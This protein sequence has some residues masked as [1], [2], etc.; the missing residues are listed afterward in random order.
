MKNNLNKTILAVAIS[1]I[2]SASANAAITDIIISE[3]V[4]GTGYNKAIELTNTG[5]EDYTFTSNI[6][7]QW[8]AYNNQ[9]LDAD[10]NNVLE[11]LKIEA[12]ATAVIYHGTAGED[13]TNAIIASTA[14]SVRAATWG[15]QGYGALN[16]NGDDHV[17]LIDT[18]NIDYDDYEE[19]DLIILDIIG[20]FG[21]EIYWGK[22]QTLRRRYGE[23]DV[24][25][26]QSS[27]Y[28]EFEW[29]VFDVDSFDDLGTATYS[30]YQEGG[31]ALTFCVLD[32]QTL[33]SEAQGDGGSSPLID[34]GYMSD[35][36]YDFT[37]IV[38]AVTRY[39]VRGFYMQ[40]VE[41][42]GDVAT[43]DGI[44]VST[45]DA[46]DDMVGNT[47]CVNSYVHEYYSLTRL[48]TDEW[49]IVDETSSVPEAT[50]IEIISADGGSFNAT[51]ERYEGM[52][53]RLPEDL[54][55]NTTDSENMRVTQTFG[56]N[57]DTYRNSMIL[58]YKRPNMNP[59]Q[60]NVAG[61]DEA[62]EAAAENIDYRLIIESKESADDG[63]IPYYPAFSSNPDSNYIRINDSVI[64]MEGVVSYSYGDFN[65]VVTNELTSSNFIHNTDR[66]DSPDLETTTTDDSFVIKVGAQNV[67]NLFNSPFGGDENIHGDNRG[68]ESE[69][70]Y[71][72]QLA[73]IVSAIVALDADIVG[74]MEIENN[75]YGRD[76]AI[77]ALIDAVNANYWDEDPKDVDTAAS[78]SNRYVF[79]GYDENGDLVLDSLDSLGSDAI[80][81]GLIYRPT[82][83]TIE[84]MQVI[85]M[86]EQHAPVV[87]NDNNVVVKDSSG[88]VLESGDN[89]QRETIAATFKVNNTGK[90]LTI[91]VNHFKSKGSTCWED[92]DGV[93][94]GEEV[95]WSDDAP[96]EDLQGSCENLRVAASVQ[97]GEE[98]ADVGGDRII[99][100]D[101]NSYNQ[102]DPLLVLTEN[103]TNKT[104]MAARD[105]F[106][107]DKPQFTTG[108]S[109][110][111]ITKTYGYINAVSLKNE[112]KNQTS[113]SYSY[114]D[115]IGSLD[116]I[117]ISPS[118]ETRLIDAVDWHINAA[119]SSLYDYADAYKGDYAASFYVGDAF[120]SSDHDP[121]IIA[122]SY[123]YGEVENGERVILT[124]DSRLLTIPYLLGEGTLTS[125]IIRI[126]LSSEVNMSDVVLPNLS[127]TEDNQALAEI[128]V[129]GL[130]TGTYT[131]TMTLI[132]DDE[133]LT[134]FTEVM[135]FEAI[136]QDSTIATVAP[137]EEY[138]GS[139]GSIG[140]FGL[141][142]LFG[143]GFLRNRKKNDSPLKI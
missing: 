126:S 38:T 46:T 66:T 28:N 44:F 85:S 35:N 27:S 62:I 3:Y 140:I 98:L 138:D 105:T 34:S 139:G 124:L 13:L 43:S 58:A 10:G 25:P 87:V 96:N 133:V 80:T 130:E 121:V 16:F 39:P 101:L 12:G 55:P 92:W 71:Q 142:S 47:V 26:V 73:K 137:V 29:E 94:F 69:D 127:L 78:I 89:Y 88:E 50:D 54:N 110:Q 86:P 53:V 67:L 141:L 22:D 143:L 108:G 95:T 18:S 49:D 36:A 30:P 115:E 72:K 4:E 116:H 76:S 20:T 5:S 97:L 132:R 74:L 21:T 56:F 111:E 23:G 61:S 117:L 136:N 122:L 90:T 7:L 52:L 119:E 81:T 125:D 93:A 128:E 109:A 33:I 135:R 42:D 114:N 131:A 77:Q 6:D 57:Y 41:P 70:E 48:V 91:A 84:S 106:I 31:G 60:D 107:G 65:L 63:E 8:G 79:V 1:G 19:E 112:E 99:V 2:L 120:R 11:D 40:D 118:L 32:E 75:G 102:E 59:T 104:I 123:Q 113:W 82:K 17:A 45:S 37:G 51:L 103:A 64:G 24:T 68:A 129:F 100:G 134:E 14:T 83:V 9:V 15:E